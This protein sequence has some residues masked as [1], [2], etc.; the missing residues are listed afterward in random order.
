MSIEHMPKMRRR[1]GRVLSAISGLCF[2]C[3]LIFIVIDF[4]G[5]KWTLFL[6]VAIACLILSSVFNHPPVLEHKDANKSG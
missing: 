4:K 3:F 2:L 5:S 6:A 1:M